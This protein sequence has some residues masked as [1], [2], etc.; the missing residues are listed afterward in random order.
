MKIDVTTPRGGET[1]WVVADRI[2]FLG[3]IPGSNF[4]LLDFLPGGV[5]R[6][7]QRFGRRIRTG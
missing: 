5:V 6:H 7:H 1:L 2:R 4:E 3:G